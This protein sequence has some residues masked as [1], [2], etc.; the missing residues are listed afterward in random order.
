MTRETIKILGIMLKGG[1]IIR[2]SDKGQCW[3]VDAG[4]NYSQIEETI[5]TE[6]LKD[7]GVYPLNEGC[8]SRY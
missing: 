1:Y 6:A 2:D 3:V 5:F 7:E 4:G 8:Y